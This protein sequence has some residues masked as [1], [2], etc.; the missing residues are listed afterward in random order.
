MP[1]LEESKMDLN[2]AKTCIINHTLMSILNNARTFFAK[3]DEADED[4]KKMLRSE[5]NNIV[6]N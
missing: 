4:N 2:S 1:L 6:E 5:T 3:A